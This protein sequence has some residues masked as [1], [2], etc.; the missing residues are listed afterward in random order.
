MKKNTTTPLTGLGILRDLECFD[1]IEIEQGIQEL[2]NNIGPLGTGKKYFGK[3]YEE[4]LQV[5]YSLKKFAENRQLNIEIHELKETLINKF[6]E[7]HGQSK[8]WVKVSKIVAGLQNQRKG[9]EFLKDG[10]IREIEKL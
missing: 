1:L 7:M 4:K 5:L 3:L 2:E 9:R 6:T 8:A 10:L